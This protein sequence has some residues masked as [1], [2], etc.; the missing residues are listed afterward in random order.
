VV[1]PVA[2]VDS[3]RADEMTEGRSHAATREG[4]YP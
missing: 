3:V 4:P 1:S 2:T